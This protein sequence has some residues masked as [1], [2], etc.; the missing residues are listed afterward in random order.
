[1]DWQY[2][3]SLFPVLTGAIVALML[4]AY[5]W[6][7]R[8]AAGALPF[9]FA[10]LAV[11]GWSLSY[12][13]ELGSQTFEILWLGQRLAYVGM[14]TLPFFWWWFAWQYVHTTPGLKRPYLLLFLIIP[15]LTLLLVWTNELHGLM[16]REVA[17]G[18]TAGVSMLETEAGWWFWVHFAYSYA[19]LLGGTAV[20]IWRAAQRSSFIYRGQIVLLVLGVLLPWVGDALYV[21]KLTPV[22]WTP[23][24]FAVGG[25]LVAW[26]IFQANLFEEMPP[27]QQVVWDKIHD[28][29]IVLDKQNGIVGTNPAALAILGKSEREVRGQPAASLFTA[30]AAPLNRFLSG[31][32]TRTEIQLSSHGGESRT[33]E[34]Q[35]TTLRNLLK[36]ETGRLLVLRD[37]TAQKAAEAALRTQK[38]L[39]EGLLALAPAVAEQ[40]ALATG[41]HQTLVKLVTLI[42]ASGGS[43]YLPEKGV[44]GVNTINF[45]PESSEGEPAPDTVQSMWPGVVEWVFHHG[46]LLNV[47]D[48]QHDDRWSTMRYRLSHTRSILAVPL[49]SSEGHTLGVLSVRQKRPGYFSADHEELLLVAAEQMALVIHSTLMLDQQRLASDRQI[50]TYKLLRR[51]GGLLEPEEMAYTAAAAV[52]ELT[53]WDSVAI[54][55][56]APPNYR[57]SIQAAVGVLNID[58]GVNGRAYRTGATQKYPDPRNSLDFQPPLPAAYS[59][60]AV[61]LTSG[62][63]RLGVFNVQ[64]NRPNGF[65]QEEVMLAESMA[66]AIVLALDNA[67]LYAET[68]RRLREQTALRNAGNL[69]S[70]TL[71]LN[72]I[73]HT[74]AQQMGQLIDATSVIICRYH[75]PRA[76]IIAEYFSNSAAL[77]GEESD[78]GLTYYIPE[79]LPGTTEFLDAGKPQTLYLTDS[80]PTYSGHVHRHSLRPQSILLIPLQVNDQTIAFAELWESRY[81][82]QFTPEEIALCQSLAQQAAVAMDKARL[83]QAIASEQG[84]LAAI[85][86]AN[87]DGIALIGLDGEILVTNQTVLDFLRLPGG[88]QAWVGK[89]ILS[90]LA[91]LRRTA[92]HF[93]KLIIAD[94]RRWQTGS[95]T[96]HEGEFELASRFIRWRHLPVMSENRP[97]GRL[98][99]LRDVTEERLVAQ[100]RDD[101]V[102]TMVHDMRGPL[103]SVSISLHLLQRFLDQSGNEQ[104][105]M[106]LEQASK[107]MNAALDLVNAIL[108]INRLESG[109]IK[110]QYESFSLADLVNRVLEWQRPLINE[111]RLRLVLNLPPD[112]PPGC[113]DVELLV[114]V[115]QNL[116]GNAIKFSPVEGEITVIA[117]RETAVSYQGDFQRDYTADRLRVSILDNGPGIAPELHGRIFQKFA[118]G[119]EAAGSGLGLYFCKMVIEAHG[120]QIWAE[121]RVPTGTILHFTLPISHE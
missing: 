21:L 85:I 114:R 88:P 50:L 22:N 46:R 23:V 93:V 76:T 71:D 98:F 26:H 66:E 105:R 12:A 35:V 2:S 20:I 81:R 121:N 11:T 32:D 51:V 75:A 37:V 111:K 38:Q 6:Q 107:S 30:R 9:A 97:I 19:L 27:A 87:R 84:R 100:M 120:E 92:P 53:G 17:I 60:L 45:Q 116:L 1:M 70:S 64:V 118:K 29:I 40:Q 7:R 54:S 63:R 65:S 48:L 43:L 28:A 15:V 78:I 104:S 113:A 33:Y 16:W 106:T 58:E 52:A 79:D 96:R 36:Q 67:R 99:V 10:M 103:T 119:G 25:L 95:S 61:P 117:Q 42:G 59:I 91:R 101:L 56:A 47:S 80:S 77:L 74:I 31:G 69:L 24:G 62:R 73:L 108:D 83:F 44:A 110:L 86:E 4:S 49:G 55:T 41:L 39:F 89:S 3:P 90:V 94:L 18:T 102:H 68:E 112:L 109:H 8:R 115:L 34:L 14:A 72:D 82:R 13:L 5:A 57:L